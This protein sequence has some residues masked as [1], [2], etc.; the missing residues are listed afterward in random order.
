V[1][2]QSQ[3][4]GRGLT[5][6]SSRRRSAALRGAADAERWAAARP[7]RGGL[8]GVGEAYGV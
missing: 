1:R 2:E 3:N 7:R 5:P 8:E 4:L 6:A